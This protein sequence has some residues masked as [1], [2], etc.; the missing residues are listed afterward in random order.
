MMECRDYLA[1][2]RAS[3]P[4]DVDRRESLE[5][6]VAEGATIHR[7]PRVVALTEHLLMDSEQYNQ[8]EREL[9]AQLAQADQP[10]AA[11]LL[12]LRD[13]VAETVAA[14]E[15]EQGPTPEFLSRRA[16]KPL[17]PQLNLYT[18]DEA[19]MARAIAELR[20]VFSDA[21]ST[22][23]A[24]HGAAGDRSQVTLL[25]NL[26]KA[27]SGLFGESDFRFFIIRDPSIHSV[28]RDILVNYIFSKEMLREQSLV[29][30]LARG[31]LKVLL[32]QSLAITLASFGCRGEILG[33][34][35]VDACVVVN[36]ALRDA[37]IKAAL[38]ASADV[39]RHL[40]FH[41][42]QRVCEGNR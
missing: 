36:K 41:Q 24:A 11:T 30:G 5:A 10:I 15:T 6:L 19:G 1:A 28:L 20:K 40:F 8:L 27:V 9:L 33:R 13:R 42:L 29:D 26:L 2:K 34:D 37:R 3:A 16:W 21:I 31:A 23:T 38:T 17:L 35:V 25:E 39:I 12:A 14:L 18:S 22:L 4:L 7:M 32:T